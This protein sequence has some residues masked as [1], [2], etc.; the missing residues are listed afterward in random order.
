MNKKELTEA[1]LTEML[2][3]LQ[4]AKEFAIEQ[5]PLVIQEFYKW[6]M[7]RMVLGVIL[8][9]VLAILFGYT[10]R[11]LW[12]KIL[13]DDDSLIPLI[14]FPGGACIGC[15]IQLCICVYNMVFIWLAPR[16][17]LIEYL[18]NSK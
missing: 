10:T 6:E 9:G 11:A 17:Y 4:T 12:K 3:W 8:F 14:I 15:F 18:K 7:G 1:I 16:V 13:N 5:A 2:G